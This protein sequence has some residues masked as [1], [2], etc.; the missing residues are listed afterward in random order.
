MLA[1][2]AINLTFRLGSEIV[3]EWDESLYAITAWEAV[4]YGRWIGTTFLGS[5]DYY[6]SKPP[7]NVWLIGLAFEAF[8]PSLVSLRLTSVIAAWLTVAV[9]QEWT[10]R[11]FGPAVALMAGLVLEHELRI[12]LRPFRAE[13][14]SRRTPRLAHTVDSR[15]I[16][17]ARQNPWRRAW[18]GPIAAAVFLLKG[19]AVLMPLTIIVGAECAY[20]R[21]KGTEWRADLAAV[22][23]FLSPIAIWAIA[24]WQVDGW[25]FFRHM[26]QNDLIGV[27]TKV[28]D[29]HTGGPL[30]YANVLQK[31]HFDWLAAGVLSCLLAPFS[32]S[33]LRTHVDRLSARRC[34][35]GH[36]H[37]GG[38]R[39]AHSH[40]DADEAT[41][42]P[43]FVLPGLCNRRGVAGRA[44]AVT[45]GTEQRPSSGGLRDRRHRLLRRRMPLDLVSYHMRDLAGHV[46]GM[47][48]ADGKTVSG[49]TVFGA[50][51][52]HADRF[53]LMAIRAGAEEATGVNDFMAKSESGDYLV[54]VR[55]FDH[56]ALVQVRRN[57][58]YVLYQRRD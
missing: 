14:Q 27:T 46:Q 2:A 4:E 6:N 30:Y 54:A 23:L 17:G 22:L 29:G 41:L 9:L 28:L 18:L 1:L 37:L 58:G 8:G 32:W 43:Q 31:N 5:L 49:R 52:D 13:R 38:R 44:R 39:R 10:R 20:P 3:T 15:H 25:L 16:V 11:C 12:S 33:A 51:W 26:L 45:R 36:R 35:S 24:R 40:R 7:L 53:V 50:R 57:A 42:V 55:E 19:P 48:L 56:P 34:D 21:R 47:L